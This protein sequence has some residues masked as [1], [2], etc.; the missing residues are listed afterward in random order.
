MKKYSAEI[1]R[2]ILTLPKPEFPVLL[3]KMSRG[4]SAG[5]DRHITIFS[6]EGRLYQVGTV[7][8]N[9]VRFNANVLIICW[10]LNSLLQIDAE[11][12]PA[13]AWACCLNKLKAVEVVQWLRKMQL[14]AT[15]CL[16]QPEQP[17]WQSWIWILGT[18]TVFNTA[19]SD[20]TPPTTLIS[21][22]TCSFSRFYLALSWMID[23]SV[24]R[25]HSGRL[26]VDCSD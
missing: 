16:M 15:A 24:Y 17:G 23:Y 22:F 5:F 4:S 13:M 6:P 18:S 1:R 20:R 14:N 10:L 19:L 11:N 3:S 2:G 7:V 12:R 9:Y 25:L 26:S 8:Y 21:C